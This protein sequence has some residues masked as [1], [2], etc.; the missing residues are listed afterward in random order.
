MVKV[1]QKYDAGHKA[2][3]ARKETLYGI[4]RLVNWSTIITIQNTPNLARA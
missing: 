1:P 2:E 3:N 4:K